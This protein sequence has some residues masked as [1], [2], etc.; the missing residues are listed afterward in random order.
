MTSHNLSLWIALN[1]LATIIEKKES[2]VEDQSELYWRNEEA[3]RATKFYKNICSPFL[4][5]S[6][7]RVLEVGSSQGYLAKLLKTKVREVHVVESDEDVLTMSR[8][9][10]KDIVIH[11]RALQTMG[12]DLKFDLIIHVLLRS[13]DPNLW[14]HADAWRPLVDRLSFDQSRSGGVT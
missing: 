7:R 9:N 3:L 4:D 2:P 10:Y 11:H 1:R 8:D 6:T 13:C 12:T 5:D 14:C